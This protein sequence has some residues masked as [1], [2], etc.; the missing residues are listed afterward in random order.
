M[1][2]ERQ[3]RKSLTKQGASTEA[4]FFDNDGMDSIRSVSLPSVKPREGVKDV[5]TKNLNLR[6]EIVGGRRS[7]RIM[8]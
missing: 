3:R 6:H 2:V 7:R 8:P 4:Q 1:E 5:I